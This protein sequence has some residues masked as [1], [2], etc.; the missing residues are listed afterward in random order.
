MCG[1]SSALGPAAETNQSGGVWAQNYGP[2]CSPESAIKNELV[3]QR[4]AVFGTMLPPSAEATCFIAYNLRIT[5]PQ[6]RHKTLHFLI[7]SFCVCVSPLGLCDY[8]MIAGGEVEVTEWTLF[9]Y[10]FLMRDTYCIIALNECSGFIQF[11]LYLQ[12]NV[13]YH[14]K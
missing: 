7:L 14:R 5:A 12:R 8:V 10:N 1:V 3:T 13:N 9:I 4:D 6:G 11:K 2:L